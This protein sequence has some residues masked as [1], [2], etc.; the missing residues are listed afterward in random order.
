MILACDAE[1][2]G[3]RPGPARRIVEFRAR[4]ENVAAV[5]ITS[6]DEH[7]AVGQQRRRMIKAAGVEAAGVS[8]NIGSTR[9]HEQQSCAQKKQ[10]ER[11]PQRKNRGSRQKTDSKR[12]QYFHNLREGFQI[13]KSSSLVP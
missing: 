1:A 3:R 11:D 6:C 13:M 12:M 2:A 8:K 4:E 7:L 10:Q 9:L 5:V